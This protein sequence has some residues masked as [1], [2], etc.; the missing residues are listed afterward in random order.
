MT[1]IAS[2]IQIKKKAEKYVSCFP[3]K[4]ITV[5]GVGNVERK[6]LLP[7]VVH[8]VAAFKMKTAMSICG[9]FLHHR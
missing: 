1:E 4:C 5:V 6:N 2:N 7:V 3:E 9:F 8:V